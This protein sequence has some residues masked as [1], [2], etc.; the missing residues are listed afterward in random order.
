MLLQ[1]TDLPAA[2]KIAQRLREAVAALGIPHARS[3][4]AGHVTVSVGVASGWGQEGVSPQVL[5]K[6]ADGAL[7]E[8]RGGGDGGCLLYTSPSPRDKRQSRMPSSA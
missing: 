2:E 7:G 3:V 5:V 1:D 6:A 8:A 4:A